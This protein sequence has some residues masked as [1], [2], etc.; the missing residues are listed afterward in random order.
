MAERA[1]QRVNRYAQG[2]RDGRQ[3]PSRWKILGAKILLKA[4]DQ[5]CFRTR[6]TIITG[7]CVCVTVVGLGGVHLHLPP[8]RHVRFRH[9]LGALRRVADALIQPCVAFFSVDRRCDSLIRSS[10]DPRRGL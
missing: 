2:G 4:R 6:V 1:G 7:G 9:L 3:P 5:P 10:A 8:V